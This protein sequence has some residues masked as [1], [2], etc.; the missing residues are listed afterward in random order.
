MMD[1]KFFTWRW[2]AIATFLLGVILA[3]QKTKH[4][5]KNPVHM[6]SMN[7]QKE[8][9]EFWGDPKSKLCFLCPANL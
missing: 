6:M 9:T 3:M 2:S 7:L 5:L 1:E 8:R 4:S